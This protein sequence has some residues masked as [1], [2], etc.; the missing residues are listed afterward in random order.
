MKQYTKEDLVNFLKWN[1]NAPVKVLR[2]ASIEELENFLKRGNAFD[3]FIETLD[4]Y[5][6]ERAL[7]AKCNKMR[8]ALG[9][10]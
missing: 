10:R 3:K 8:K 5:R 4:L 7:E 6:E 1:S 9:I 2:N